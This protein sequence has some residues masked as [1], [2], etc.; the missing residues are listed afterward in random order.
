MVLVQGLLLG[1]RRGIGH[2]RGPGHGR[3]RIRLPH[4][5]QLTRHQLNLRLSIAHAALVGQGHPAVEVH[6]G[7][8]PG[9][10]G[11]IVRLPAHAAA[12]IRELQGPLP[13]PGALKMEHQGGPVTQGLGHVGE[14]QVAD[15]AGL[16]AIGVTQHRALVGREYA[17]LLDRA[18][19]VFI[20]A[21]DLHGAADIFLEQALRGEQVEVEVLLD[22]PDPRTAGSLGEQ[23][24]L[25]ADVLGNVAPG[26]TILA[27]GETDPAQV[28]HQGQVRVVDRDG[29]GLLGAVV[30][31]LLGG[32]DPIH[33]VVLAGG[34][35]GDD[36]DGGDLGGRGVR[37]GN[38]AQGQH[39]Q[40]DPRGGAPAWT[41]VVWAEVAWTEVAWTEMARRGT[42]RVQTWHG[43]A[44]GR[45][46]RRPRITPPAP[47]GTSPFRDDRRGAPPSAPR[48]ARSRNAQ[49]PL[50]LRVAAPLIV[51]RR[52]RFPG[53]PDARCNA[54]SSP[55][56]GSQP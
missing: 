25:R 18:I 20:G 8:V 21:D 41:E 30:D 13:G 44:P 26:E 34:V 28:L 32:L 5:V 37:R 14:G 4:P 33:C 24:R 3:G 56:I 46:R 29:H 39:R 23:R 43:M 45:L 22:E 6:A 55:A 47:L 38:H 19:P 48:S 7:A 52:R 16:D 17:G 51:P 27:G 10:V 35:D 50:R 9:E 36:L 53:C 49:A 12:E 15:H 1:H 31:P 11:H 54:R 42:R 2:H 40:Q